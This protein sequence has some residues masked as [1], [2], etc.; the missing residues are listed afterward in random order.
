MEPLMQITP[1][2]SVPLAGG[3]NN[4]SV[5]DAERSKLQGI[6]SGATA[7][8]TNAQLRDRTTH[9]GT[10]SADTVVDGT[11]NKVF[12]A[13]EQTRLLALGAVVNSAAGTLVAIPYNAGGAYVT[14]QTLVLPAGTYLV[15]HEGYYY[16]SGHTL[17]EE[18][19]IRLRDTTN[20]VT[21]GERL[22]AITP[23]NTATH[24]VPFAATRRIVGPCTVEVQ[25]NHA[26]GGG[27]PVS[28][29]ATVQA[30]RVA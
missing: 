29:L 28:V 12:T 23:G 8:D 26:A 14:V 9:T 7:N 13:T 15:A 6:A 22:V 19:A 24:S 10:Q 11:T 2:G 17:R 27:Q 21:H 1:A 18:V 25:A 16:I 20:S 30:T 5:T 3:G 4:G